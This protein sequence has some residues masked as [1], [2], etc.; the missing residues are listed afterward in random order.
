MTVPIFGSVRSGGRTAVVLAVSLVACSGPSGPSWIE[1][2]RNVAP[3]DAGLDTEADTFLTGAPLG[4][5]GCLSGID[6]P[7]PER[8][9]P[10][11]PARDGERGVGNDPYTA[12]G[13]RQVPG[14]DITLMA[15]PDVPIEVVVAR[16]MDPDEHVA[17]R[18]PDRAAT[19]PVPAPKTIGASSAP[20][21]TV[22]SEGQATE[23]EP[24]CDQGASP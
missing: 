7:V 12:V 10:P 1:E 5:G 14:P 21:S 19:G 22:P 23:D 11:P 17:A 18:Q 16:P 24:S 9:P 15:R 6:L 13:A 4:G 2:V 20:S 8:R 3:E